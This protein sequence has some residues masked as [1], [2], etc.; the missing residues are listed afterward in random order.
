[1]FPTEEIIRLYKVEKLSL[2]Q[3]AGI[4]GLTYQAVHLRLQKADV[5]RRPREAAEIDLNELRYLYCDRGLSLKETAKRLNCSTYNVRESLSKFNIPIRT[6]RSAGWKEKVTADEVVRLTTQEGWTDAEVTKKFDVPAHVVYRM[7]RK[8]GKSH[9]PIEIDRSVLRRLYLSEKLSINK[10]AKHFG[11]YPKRISN[12][13][14]AIG[15]RKI[16]SQGRRL[17]YSI[18][19]NLEIG[20]TIVVPLPSIQNPHHRFHVMARNLGITVTCKKLNET[21]MQVTRTA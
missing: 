13:L 8:A 20:T 19:E 10:I 21:E 1:M 6:G 4:T 12:E 9:K 15:L 3:I 17:D 18:I 7:R 14:S 2:R 5:E 16:K 11:V